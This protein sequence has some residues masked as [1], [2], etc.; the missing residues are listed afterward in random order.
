MLG[1]EG[2][3]VTYIIGSVPKQIDAQQLAAQLVEQALNP[4]APAPGTKAK[5][6]AAL[7]RNAHL[8][9]QKITVDISGPELTLRGT[10]RSLAE[11][12]QAQH[13]AWG[14]TGVTSVKN[15]LVV[16]S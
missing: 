9:P 8:D 2:Q 12:R 10:V 5:V 16:T 7:L 4:P 6:E 14:A 15:E 3:A 13:V 1:G 11:R